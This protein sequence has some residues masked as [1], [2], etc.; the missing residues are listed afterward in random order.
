MVFV[1]TI[2]AFGITMFSM[3]AFVFPALPALVLSL[4]GL[5]K[6]MSWVIYKL[7][8]LWAKCVILI[9]GS[10]IRVEGRENIPKEGGVCFVG[11]HVGI[12]DIILVLAY[13]GRPFG[14]I[15]KK[16]LLLVPVINLWI[17]FLGGLYID[18]RNMRKSVKA[19][20]LG[21]RKIQNGGSMLIFPEGTRS[22]GQGLLPFRSGFVKLATSSLVPIVPIAISGSYEVFEK[23][24]LVNASSVRMV[25]CPPIDTASMSIEDRKQKLTEQVHSVIE[26]ALNKP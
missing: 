26:E 24:K 23:H 7:A 2:L 22:K 8:Q 19:I 18:R 25:F 10:S 17:Y 4:L 9:T 20:N 6:A 11:N 5:K 14:F 16:E 3:F 1:K 21:I 13:I 12:F 15:A